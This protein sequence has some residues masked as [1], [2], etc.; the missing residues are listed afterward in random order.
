MSTLTTNT[1]QNIY[2]IGTNTCDSSIQYCAEGYALYFPCVKEITKGQEVCFDFYI[3]DASEHDV[4][5][6][7]TVDA[8]TLNLIG[9]FNCPYGS[10]SY[11]DNISSLQIESY[12][13]VYSDDFGT[14]T[15]CH[16][17]VIMFDVENDDSD[18]GYDKVEKGSF[19]SG[20]TVDIA[21]YDTPT[22][23]F[24][25]WAKYELD[26]EGCEDDSP[27]D[28]IVSEKHEYSF[29]IESDTILLALY[30]PRK[31][32]TI[33]SDPE[34][35][36]SHFIVNYQTI[37]SD[38][39]NRDDGYSDDENSID[40]LEGYKFVAKCIP[41]TDEIGNSD[42]EMYVFK[43]W[44]D[45]ITD[46]EREF[47][48][49]KNT[50]NFEDGNIIKLK[51]NCD[52]PVPYVDSEDD[53]FIPGFTDEFDEEGIHILTEESDIA[54]NEYYGDHIISTDD[55][56]Q[57]FIEETGYLYFNSGTL[58]L[59][60]V[61]IEDGIKINIYAKCEEPCEVSV[62]VNGYTAKQLVS[63][64]EFKLYEF[65]FNKCGGSNIEITTDG[66][67]LVDKIEVCREEFVDKGKAQLCLDHETTLNLL[68]GKLSV[69]G[70]IMIDGNSYG[71]ST[72]QIGNVNKLPKITLSINE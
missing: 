38:I 54:I 4:V 6:L 61:G 27:Y 47:T 1:I 35:K 23:I 71:L 9:P 31:K 70:A 11:P 68:S 45:G 24:V 16:L 7:K 5:D 34:N 10:F 67:C 13:V 43:D 18:A 52:G 41:S 20:T 51:A 14:R 64:D 33:V 15:L 32:Y 8:I 21:A 40:V 37:I 63:Q 58:I 12:P 29:V 53:E 30:R 57:K 36:F 25:G 19:Y 69:N 44:A 22:H 28:H 65:Y 48:V 59:S 49:G 66:E 62:S 50:S 39:S 3:A 46:I 56:Y 26:D 72:V 42:A 17:S 55:V 60:S 2:N